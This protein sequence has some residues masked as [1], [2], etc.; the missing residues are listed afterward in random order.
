MNLGV[1]LGW[2][3]WEAGGGGGGV[4][5]GSEEGTGHNFSP[6]CFIMSGNQ[7]GDKVRK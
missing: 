7:I 3:R 4:A 6:I 1:L 5:R 2:G